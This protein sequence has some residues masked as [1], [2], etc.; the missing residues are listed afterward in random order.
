MY[1]LL[2]GFLI[3]II[4]YLYKSYV[5]VLE[6]YKVQLQINKNIMNTI[7]RSADILDANIDWMD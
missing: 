2:V 3:I 6:K 5:R 1:L 4:V 7:Q